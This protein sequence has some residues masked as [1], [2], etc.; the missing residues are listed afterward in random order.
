MTEQAAGQ[1][2]GAAIRRAKNA[3]LADI[4]AFRKILMASRLPLPL[5]RLIAWRRVTSRPNAQAA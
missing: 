5:R 4:P 2:T 3:P 1:L